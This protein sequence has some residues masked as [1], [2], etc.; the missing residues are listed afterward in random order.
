MKKESL[1]LL[2]LVILGSFSIIGCPPPGEPPV[3]DLPI[4]G[5]ENPPSAAANFD[6]LILRIPNNDT[7]ALL[8][9]GTRQIE[10]YARYS[11]GAYV[12]VT[13]QVAWMS[14]DGSKATV[15]KGLV[16]AKANA[17]SVQI[18]AQYT[19][20]GKTRASLPITISLGS[21]GGTTPPPA[22]VSF[23]SVILRIPNEDTSALPQGGTR[24]IDAYAKYSDGTEVKITDQAIW[25]SSDGLR[26]AVNKGL[27]TAKDKTSSIQITAQHT[28][29]GQTRTSS[30]AISLTTPCFF[31]IDPP[32]NNTAM[33]SEELP[34][35]K[36]HLC[37]GNIGGLELS[38]YN[39]TISDKADFSNEIG[40]DYSEDINIQGGIVEL[41]LNE[42]QWDYLNWW[43]LVG[44]GVH[45]IYI[46]ISL[47][48]ENGSVVDSK[49]R[50]ISVITPKLLWEYKHDEN[51]NTS[52][53]MATISGRMMGQIGKTVDIDSIAGK[54]KL[55]L[56][57]YTSFDRNAPNGEGKF[58]LQFN[59]P[60]TVKYID[61]FMGKMFQEHRY[62]AGPGCPSSYCISCDTNSNEWWAFPNL[63]IDY[64]NPSN[65]MEE[66]TIPIFRRDTDY[67]DTVYY[68]LSPHLYYPT[69]REKAPYKS[70]LWFQNGTWFNLIQSSKIPFYI[71]KHTSYALN[72][73]VIKGKT[74]FDSNVQD[75][76]RRSCYNEPG[77]DNQGSSIGPYIWGNQL[78]SGHP[79]ANTT[80]GYTSTSYRVPTVY[81]LK[82]WGY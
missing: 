44:G 13:N 42:E 36:W 24:Q 69:S 50:T 37:A 32:A 8:Q 82:I 75:T 54:G 70:I 39:I 25:T 57:K 23:D 72:K 41:D 47:H 49:D 19:D 61:I 48:D 5:G 15:D 11:D 1:L 79:Y 29:R 16:T 14:S 28:D 64:Y 66:R 7:S 30:I 77:A 81:D 53:V 21:G 26:A 59:T 22:S 55:N 46:R 33:S 27:V 60:V 65:Q 6:D 51:N 71:K 35:L 56:G 20:R 78:G 62:L 10:A 67:Y 18:T 31:D 74:N 38:Y 12:I 4:G 9:G 76:S 58:E 17:S 3:G 43:R 2:S 45:T 63:T 40:S 68:P 80:W 73:L 34:L 52:L